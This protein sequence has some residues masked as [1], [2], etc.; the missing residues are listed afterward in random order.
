MVYILN[1][2]CSMELF[3]LFN[4]IS[5]KYSNFFFFSEINYFTTIKY[6]L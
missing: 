5:R 6:V 4:L 1:M 2:V 3:I